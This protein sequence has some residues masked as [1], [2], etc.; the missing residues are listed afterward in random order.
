MRIAG[1][2]LVGLATG[3][4]AGVAAAGDIDSSFGKSRPAS[5][6]VE[7]MPATAPPGEGRE[8][9]IQLGFD[10]RD[11]CRML[12]PNLRPACLD[13]VASRAA[14]PADPLDLPL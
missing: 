9:A 11:D 14:N 5:V 10:A 2:G 12:R 1:L 4:V 8:L 3:M 13:Y 6:A 7:P